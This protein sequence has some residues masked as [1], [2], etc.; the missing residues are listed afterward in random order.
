METKSTTSHRQWRAF[1]NPDGNEKGYLVTVDAAIKRTLEL[2]W[3]R[4]IHTFFSC[5][6]DEDWTTD[7]DGNEVPPG[8]YVMM[9]HVKAWDDLLEHW[10]NNKLDYPYKRQVTINKILTAPV[11]RKN[12][13]RDGVEEWVERDFGTWYIEYD[14]D[15]WDDRGPIVVL[16][17]PAQDLVWLQCLLEET[18]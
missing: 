7:Y 18:P 15:D 11:Y 8:G 2:L 13:K 17:F 12:S 9:S 16:R 4:G 6:G 1:Y 5:Q 14:E 10:E 3:E